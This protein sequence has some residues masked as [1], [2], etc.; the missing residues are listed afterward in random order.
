[1]FE[2]IY[3]KWNGLNAR[4][5]RSVSLTAEFFAFISAILGVT[6]FSPD[7]FYSV[8]SYRERLVMVLCLFAL[9][10]LFIREILGLIYKSAVTLNIRGIPVKIKAGDLFDQEGL[11]I[12]SFNEHYDT[13]VDEKVI[14][15]S[16]L[17]GIYIK[18]YVSDLKKLERAIKANAKEHG[19]T[20]NGDGKYCFKLG[21][22]IRFEDFLLL[23]FSKFDEQNR[24][25]IS[26]QE[27]WN[28]L[29]HMWSEVRRL[30]GDQPVFL[31]LIGSGITSFDGVPQ[32]SPEEL[33]FWILSTLK[34]SGEHINQPITIVLK[35]EM[36]EKMDLYELKWRLKG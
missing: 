8:S 19:I 11:K 34:L 29:L 18:K 6:G 15:S 17:N 27:Y 22:L 13:C 5:R 36:I 31:P 20:K 1:M 33:I 7:T 16:T 2:K 23:A 4:Y 35:K 30:Y 28:C 25:H 32:K 10:V 12:I 9:M 26:I 24:A 14:A 3:D 21:H